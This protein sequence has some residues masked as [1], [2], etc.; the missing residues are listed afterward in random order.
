KTIPIEGKFYMKWL[1]EIVAAQSALSAAK[2]FR[3]PV[4][5]ATESL[6]ESDLRLV[7]QKFLRATDLRLGMFDVAGSGLRVDR[8]DVLAR[9]LVD[10]LQ[11]RIDGNAIAASDV[12]Y[13][14]SDA[15]GLA[16]EQIRF[17]HVLHIREIT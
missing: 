17:N 13:L 3:V 12:E 14:P 10:L 4:N 1:K 9:N 11:H 15:R 16:G 7:S 6:F 5:R 2:V 8:C